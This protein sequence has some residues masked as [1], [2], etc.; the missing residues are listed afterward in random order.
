M[1]KKG[2]TLVELLVVIAIIGIL[3]SLL[4][5]AVQMAREAA[6]VAQCSNNLKQMSLACLN[7]ENSTRAFP[8]GGWGCFWSGDPEAGMGY[9]QPGSW[10]YA[11][12]PALELNALYQLP[13]DGQYPETI[14]DQH[15]LGTQKLFKS[16]V[17]AFYCP[18]RRKPELYPAYSGGINGYNFSFSG[19]MTVC[20]SDYA[21]NAGTCL[22]SGK[23]TTIIHGAGY[24]TGTISGFRSS[25]TWQS[26]LDCNKQ[27]TGILYRHSDIA[28]DDIKD[29]FSNTYL[30]GEKFLESETYTTLYYTTT[31]GSQAETGFDDYCIFCGADLDNLRATYCGWYNND[32]FNVAAARCAPLRDNKHQNVQNSNLDGGMPNSFGSAHAGSFGMAMCDGSVH[33]V[34]YNV[35]PEIHHC[36]GDRGDKQEASGSELK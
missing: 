32:V 11:I 8:S 20:K 28:A 21:G 22:N 30:I 9:K 26:A 33:R 13:A 36:K 1:N 24:P 10:H 5:P 25:G 12:L 19:G 17:P 34:S 29:G 18:S 14:T 15:K 7:I 4:L 2:F 35:E 16:V 3:M 6:R 23:E 31:S 27:Q